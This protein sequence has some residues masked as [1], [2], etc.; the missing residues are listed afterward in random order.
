VASGSERRRG[1]ESKFAVRIFVKKS[2]DFVQQTPPNR[3]LQARG[4]HLASLGDQIVR[5]SGRK[6]QLAIPHFGKRKF[7]INMNNQK[8]FAN[9]VL[10]VV[11]VLLVGVVGYLTL[12]KKSPA[13]TPTS[14]PT[15]AT[16]P[17]NSS[18][19]TNTNVK[20]YRGASFEFQYPSTLSLS[21]QGESVALTHSVAYR[22]PD[23]CDFKG[24]GQPLGKITDFS[25]S[26]RMFNLGLKDTV[27]AN[28]TDYLMNEFFSSN[29]LKT[30]PGFIDEFSVNSLQGYRVTSGV[31]GC[32]RFTY[33]FPISTNKTLF[34]SRAFISEFQPIN[35]DYQ[36]YLNVSGVIS[37]SQ[38]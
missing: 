32:G 28:E 11:I 15:P 29:T 2:S 35:A 18:D 7:L 34:V 30:S 31:E 8:G 6:N 12:V 20:T 19:N 16:P 10:V 4:S 5:F 25:V 36:K 22:H 13:P 27:K 21:V 23:P 38:E 33:Y 37:P 24:D 1:G 26:L 17:N 3:K 9:I 14:T